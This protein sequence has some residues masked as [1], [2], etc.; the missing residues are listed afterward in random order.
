MTIPDWWTSNRYGL[1][2]HASLA[3]VPAWA[4]VGHYAGWYRSHLGEA[5]DGAG[6]HPNP[7]VEVLAHHRRHW[8]EIEAYSEF[9]D[10][11]DFDRFDPDEWAEMAERAGMSHT[12]M[13][14][15]HHDGL[16]WWDAPGDVPSVMGA[17]PRRDVL[18]ELAAAAQRSGL[19]FGTYY[20]LLDW[21]DRRYPTS[22]YVD[23][24]FHPE[25]LDLVDRYGSRVLWGDGNWAQPASLW[26]SDEVLERARTIRPDLVINDRW[27]A[28]RSDFETF[29]ISLPDRV[30]DEPWELCRPIGGS[31]GHNRNELFEHHLAATDIISLLTEVVAKGGNLLL[32]V[33][34]DAH[35]RIPGAQL[36]P[37]LEAGRWIRP[38]R[39]LLD[40]ARPWEPD[41]TAIWGDTSVRYL[42]TSD[43]RTS[44]DA[45]GD[46]WHS[47]TAIDLTG[48]GR[49]EY[50]DADRFEITAA[51]TIDGHELAIDSTNSGLTI[52]PPS[53]AAAGI[54]SVY[55]VRYRPRRIETLE[56]FSTDIAAPTALAPLLADARP[57]DV[58]NLADG[59]Y[60][61]PAVLPDRV[62]LR[63]L[64]P[65]RTRI[66]RLDTAPGLEPGTALVTLGAGSRLEH[67]AVGSSDEPHLRDLSVTGADAL[68]LDVT[69][70]GDAEI[71]A[72]RATI[73][74]CAF[75][76]VTAQSVNKVRVSRS[77]LRGGQWETGVSII[78]GSDHEVEG[79]E[80]ID[81]LCA[82]RLDNT[83][84]TTIRGNH[85]TSR[86]WAIHLRDT[87]ATHVVANSITATMR[88]VDVDGGVD[89][90]VDGNAVSAGDSGCIVERGATAVTVSG[91]HWSRCRIGLLVWDAGDVWHHSNI[92]AGLLEPDLAVE[93]GP[94]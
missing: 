25:V 30:I 92:T 18:G 23:E 7:M 55:R 63:G 93:I 10:L 36:E 51:T 85:F 2:I 35:G 49:F 28:S 58:V 88:A 65:Q 56:L 77:V 6:P 82:I 13:T 19:I 50:L 79:C 54:A 42:W 41:G 87:A 94:S 24:V 37:L 43:D 46:A 83:E 26:R 22:R 80:F 67:L 76:V 44:K 72:D 81:H 29:E 47:V 90:L 48:S 21:A 69:V 33:G 16:R 32:S 40:S 70:Y 59:D 75:S 31:F 68:M 62:T 52:H 20:S 12:I 91:N 11:L 60:L 27:S 64:G 57:G 39:A 84:N 74:G 34:P 89:V 15:K 73:R 14:A 1:L 8:P 86:W 45:P 71:T 9:A 5:V 4:P 53:N 17:G 38:H 3:T 78:G 61:G 66:R